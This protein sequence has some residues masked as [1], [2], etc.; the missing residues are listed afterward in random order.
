MYH[1]GRDI[2]KKRIQVYVD[3]AERLT[4][5]YL[6]GIEAPEIDI[7]NRTF[8]VIHTGSLELDKALTYGGYYKNTF[9]EIYGAESTGKTTL[10]I[11]AI[12]TAQREGEIVAFIDAEHAFDRKYAQTLGVDIDALVFVQ[13][14]TGDEALD[15]ALQLFQSHTIGLL[16]IDSIAT[17]SP[18]KREGNYTLKQLLRNKIPQLVAVAKDPLHPATCLLLNQTRM[19]KD[20]YGDF[21]PEPVEHTTFSNFMDTIIHLTT[22]DHILDTKGNIIGNHTRADIKKDT[23]GK[24]YGQFA[25]FDILFG[26]GIS[27]ERELIAR[28]IHEKLLVQKGNQG[29]YYKKQKIA[30]DEVNLQVLLKEDEVLRIEIMKKLFPLTE[31]KR[32]YYNPM[33]WLPKDWTVLGR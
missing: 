14:D 3:L 1:F 18:K 20:L 24:T 10:A 13:P 22:I 11:E 12:I 2:F 7:H 8:P 15:I 31:T 23:I 29:I 21:T 27:M 9:V 28:G 33:R 4:N 30:S 19:V 32:E 5:D 25:T 17:L 6:V 16:I 26:K